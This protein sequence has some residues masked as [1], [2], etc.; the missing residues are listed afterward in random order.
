M[1]TT[2]PV[3]GSAPAPKSLIARF[4]GILFSPRETFQAVAA[5]P[6]VLGM[7]LTVSMLTA[8]FAAL[9]M[10][11]DAGKQAQI[12]QQVQS[13]KS[14]GFQVTDQ[15]YDQM[16]KGAGRL[17]Y[18]TGIAA[19]IFIPIVSAIFAGILFAIFNAGLGGEASY[20][21]VYSIYIHSGV[22]GV[23]SAAVSGVVNYFSGHAG[24]VANLGALLPM[25]EEKS[26]IANLLGTV[27]IFIIW[28]VIVLA[29]GLG[30][31]Y[32]RRTQPIAISLLSVYAVIALAIAAF[33]SRGGA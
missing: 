21:Q 25:L 6:K 26:F 3:A 27:D 33:K 14:L 29:I 15:V 1:T 16:E 28:S 32:K 4:I 2:A 17:P 5:S 12:D 10:T 8:A 24:S 18:T 13:M 31:L 7:L 19:F 23:V 30:V 9:P 22:I 11:T 20:K